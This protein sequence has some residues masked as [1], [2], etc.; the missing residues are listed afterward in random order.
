LREIGQWLK[1]YGETVYGTRGGPVPPKHWGVTTQRGSLIYAH[2]LNPESDVIV[3]PELAGKVK[4]AHRYIDKTRIEF[5]DTDMGL[6]LR[7]PSGTEDEVD[8][9]IELGI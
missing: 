6:L 3:I 7:I 9:I 2:I 1:I 4:S 5:R 8:T